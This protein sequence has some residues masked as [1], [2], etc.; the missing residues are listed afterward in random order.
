MAFKA[1]WL[2]QGYGTLNV[3]SGDCAGFGSLPVG[4]RRSLSGSSIRSVGMLIGSLSVSHTDAVELLGFLSHDSDPVIL[5][6]NIM[7]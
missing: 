4:R 1:L 6:T 7:E 5:S 3:A 2:L